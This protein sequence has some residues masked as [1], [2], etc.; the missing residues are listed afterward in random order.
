MSS[1]NPS[2]LRDIVE[3]KQASTEACK[4]SGCTYDAYDRYTSHKCKEQALFSVSM[5]GEELE[6]WELVDIAS[7]DEAQRA[8]EDEGLIGLRLPLF[9][10]VEQL[11]S[12]LREAGAM[13]AEASA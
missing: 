1:T 4:H 5:S 2:A 10:S 11:E 12:L 6:S 13:L 8:V 3:L 9:C 7:P